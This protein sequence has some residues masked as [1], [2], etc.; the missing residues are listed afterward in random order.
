MN[1]KRLV[2]LLILM[3]LPVIKLQAQTEEPYY[4]VVDLDINETTRLIEATIKNTG[5][6]ETVAQSHWLH[7]RDMSNLRD[8][9]G[10]T[11]AML[12]TD[13]EAV[14][15]LDSHNF[16]NK[17]N[18]QIIYNPAGVYSLEAWVNSED[19]FAKNI[20]KELRSLPDLVVEDIRVEQKMGQE[21]VD[22]GPANIIVVY[23]NISETP[24]TGE[25]E[26]LHNFSDISEYFTADNN[27]Q[28]SIDPIYPDDSQP[29]SGNNLFKY[30]Y[31]GEFIK[32]G[33]VT[34][35]AEI[36]PN[37]KIEEIDE[38]NKKGITFTIVED[39]DISDEATGTEETEYVRPVYH[40]YT[41]K[42]TK[43]LELDSDSARIYWDAGGAYCFGRYKLAKSQAELENIHWTNSKNDIVEPYGSF[44][45][46]TG[47][48]SNTKYYLEL[49]KHYISQ[50]G[51][52]D[53]LGPTKILEFT[54]TAVEANNNVEDQAVDNNNNLDP[55]VELVP[56]SNT[57][58]PVE[59][60]ESVRMG[61][62]SAPMHARLKGRI[63]LKVE[64]AGKAYYIHP[65]KE[66]MYYLGRPDDAFMVMRE[67]GA[68]IT[69]KDL[70]RI[71]V[72]VAVTGEDTDG[73]G[74]S[75]YLET[76][77]GLD[78]GKADTDGDGYS[79]KEELVNGYSPWG[80][81]KQ[82]IDNSFAGKQAGKIFLQVEKQ[83]EAWYIN[84]TDGRR[85][86][87]GR[88][89]DAFDVMRNLG[90]GISNNDFSEL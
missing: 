68:G 62:K 69:N 19:K 14:I 15:T 35:R 38:R 1:F 57:S 79:D 24:Y 89:A 29:A 18:S 80:E 56:V 82:N 67:Q 44:V 85:Y 66:E 53:L 63:M 48:D 22:I 2:T 41:I 11:I 47:L 7:A 88:P 64:D 5:A 81:G 75:D 60:K 51:M 52:D 32:T 16:Q 86:F 30:Y 26:M 71:P 90:L 27:G 76:T 46:L 70:Y 8:Y 83:G 39:L 6:P 17:D 10:L 54:T 28:P 77:L 73:D 4:I 36:D 21:E 31:S 42:T 50:D 3:A 49:V 74:L 25:V 55:S 84:P 45:E 12:D 33:N 87:L 20:E 43:I 59:K 23:K 40:E 34:I 65:D 58:A 37:D 9:L 61:V 72:G 13:E 78:S